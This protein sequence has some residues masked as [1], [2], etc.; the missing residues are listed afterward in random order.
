MN[1]IS[2]WSIRNPI[3]PI[4]LFIVLTVA[5]SVAFM[6]L[7]V[8]QNPSVDI[9]V[10]T[11]TISQAGVAAAELETQVTRRVETAIAGISGVRHV[12]STV[13]TGNSATTI[14]F[15]L[16][17]PTDRAMNDVKDAV[18]RIRGEL[19][20][21]IDE[22]VISRVDAEG[23]AILTYAIAAPDM[24]P[25]QLTWFVDDT[26]TRALRSVPGVGQVVR[27][28]GVD[29]EIRVALDLSRLN[30]LG[31]TADDVNTQL[32]LSSADL[33]AG[34]SEAGGVNQPI[35][36][37]GAASSVGA[38]MDLQVALPR[39]GWVRLR[40]LAMVTDGAGEIR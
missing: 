30:A 40:D 7:P 36:T 6:R 16:E 23:A 22:P 11:V 31:I 14:E 1:G 4:L 19:P 3:A 5:G 33:P 8:N 35:R 18:T 34:R 15:R 38:L 37:L 26:I 2:A 32:R 10:I 21:A 24:A 28:G 29:R 9:P 27:K 20:R 25:E 39:G 13:A 17:T 12:T